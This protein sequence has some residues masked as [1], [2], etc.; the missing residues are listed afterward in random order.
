MRIWEKVI[1]VK[2]AA[3]AD[4]V[5][6]ARQNQRFQ[7]ASCLTQNKRSPIWNQAM[8]DFVNIDTFKN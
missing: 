4:R 3:T 1:V 7:V 2:S 8:L 6:R 5:D